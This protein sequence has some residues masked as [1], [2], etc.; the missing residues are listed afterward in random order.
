MSSGAG[1]SVDRTAIAH[2]QGLNGGASTSIV[3]NNEFNRRARVSFSGWRLWQ[4]EQRRR[5]ALYSVTRARTRC[6][7]TPASSVLPSSSVR[8]S[9]SRVE[10]GGGAATT[11]NFVGLPRSIDAVQFDRHPPFHSRLS[12]FH[13]PTLAPPC[14]GWS[15]A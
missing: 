10:W 1:E 8:L 2:R 15:P 4:C 5:S 12:L 13:A 11:G 7:Y 9:G 14:L 3:P 6:G